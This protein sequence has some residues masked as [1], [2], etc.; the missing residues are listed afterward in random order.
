MT[1][2]A[3]ITWSRRFFCSG[4]ACVAVLGLGLT[5]TA[6]DAGT[7]I[8]AVAANATIPGS[9]NPDPCPGGAI[10]PNL[11]TINFPFAAHLQHF[12]VPPGITSLSLALVGGGGA[13]GGGTPPT[14]TGA[15]GGDI[16][17]NLKVTVGEVFTIVT[18][19]GGSDGTAT[20]GGAGGYGG[21]GAGGA[22]GG[23]GGGATLF[24]GPG[25][26]VQ[27]VAG[28]G[29]GGALQSATDGTVLGQ[30]GASGGGSNPGHLE[31]GSNCSGLPCYYGGGGTQS[32]GGA[33]GSSETGKT[34]GT[35]GAG[36]ATGATAGTGG[37]GGSDGGGGGGGGYYGGGGGGDEG[38]STDN[39]G[40]GA[41]GGSAYAAPDVTD[42]VVSGFPDDFPWPLTITYPLDCSAPLSATAKATR[43]TASGV[44]TVTLDAKIN[45]V[46]ICGIPDLIVSSPAT[47]HRRATYV[48][49]PLK[50][51]SGTTARAEEVLSP[52]DSCWAGGF[53]RIAQAVTTAY[54]YSPP[55]DV[56][57][58]RAQMKTAKAV[59]SPIGVTVELTVIGLPPANKCGHA[60]F[61][62]N[63]KNITTLK[64]VRLIF[65]GGTVTAHAVR[66]PQPSNCVV[67]IHFL[68]I[69]PSGIGAPVSK[70]VKFSGGPPSGSAC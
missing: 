18:G 68:A 45:P 27:L 8:P 58:A 21:G 35:D 44:I 62:I 39:F 40:V 12:T 53:V 65:S 52:G 48:F 7:P 70:S 15:S 33:G 42:V 4:L 37:K 2:R 10:G 63:N 25:G 13:S 38:T 55:V 67:R 16:T 30:Q 47:A 59:R 57:V 19:G 43:D 9:T 5:G 20:K 26:K 36:P 50:Q 14:P 51:I 69:P 17:G 22:G 29:G 24:E 11:C 46:E 41:G 1:R 64:A 60:T 32:A 56:S 23:G 28:G 34:P 31:G 3:H 49:T 54:R 61:R 66:P 6:A